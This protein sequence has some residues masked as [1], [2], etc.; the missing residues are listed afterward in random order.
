[1]AALLGGYVAWRDLHQL[2]GLPTATWH[3]WSTEALKGWGAYLRQGWSRQGGW[4]QQVRAAAMQGWWGK[5][6]GMAWKGWAALC[7][8]A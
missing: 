3:G 8:P 1:M 4:L 6:H 7:L 2:S 5:A